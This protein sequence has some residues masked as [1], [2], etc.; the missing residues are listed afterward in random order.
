MRTLSI[1]SEDP[2]ERYAY[3]FSCLVVSQSGVV[4][5]GRTQHMK[6]SPQCMPYIIA[7]AQMLSISFTTL[8][9]SAIS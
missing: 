2:E 3:L 6:H 1:D 9:G 4:R 8:L 7:C 5:P